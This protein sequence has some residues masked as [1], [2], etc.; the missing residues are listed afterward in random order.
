MNRLLIGSAALLMSVAYAGAQSLDDLNIQIHGYATQGF[1]YTTNNNIF[2]MN[3]SDGS[4]A[5]TEAVVNVTSDPMPKLRVGVQARYFLMGNLGNAITLD[6]ASADYKVND[7]FGV[8]FGKVK[9]P[10]GL[11]NEVQD[12]D[13]AYLWALLPS[14]NYQVTSRSFLLSDEGGV[15]YGTFPIGKKF[16]KFEYRAWGGE[17]LIPSDDGYFIAFKNQGI[18]LPNGI[19]QSTEGATIH[20]KSK[21]G[22][23]LGASEIRYNGSLDSMTLGSYSGHLTSTAFYLPHYFASYEHKK[24]MAAYEYSRTALSSGLVVPGIPVIHAAIDACTW[25]A[26][27]SYKLTDKLT[28]GIY[29]DQFFNRSNPLGPNRYVKDWSFAGRYDFNQYLYAKVQQESVHGTSQGYDSQENPGGLK[30]NTKLTILKV[31]V[32]F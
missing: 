30:P 4:P 6:W 11:F 3:S 23:L 27:A 17:N 15:I 25:Y 32:S 7:T 21:F 9:V 2:T 5:W 24:F 16:G 1:V 10:S 12:I 18:T 29:D 22:L 14:G 19:A 20:L 13:P 26:M 28:V 31:G 8:R